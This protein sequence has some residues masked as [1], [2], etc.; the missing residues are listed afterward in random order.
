MK[1]FC[2]KDQSANSH[3]RKAS[4]GASTQKEVFSLNPKDLFKKGRRLTGNSVAAP[5]SYLL[6]VCF[7]SNKRAYDDFRQ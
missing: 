3:E 2:E 4:E 7:L 5:A 6:I 1:S